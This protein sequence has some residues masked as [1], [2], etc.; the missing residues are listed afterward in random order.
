MKWLWP[1]NFLNPPAGHV[2]L[3]S[4]QTFFLFC[5]CCPGSRGS[6]LRHHQGLC[7]QTAAKAEPPFFTFV[8]SVFMRAVW[9]DCCRTSRRCSRSQPC[10]AVPCRATPRH[11]GRPWLID[12][13]APMNQWA[14]RLFNHGQ[15]LW[16]LITASH[17]AAP[18]LA[19]SALFKRLLGIFV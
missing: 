12:W 10:R 4:N 3:A 11:A 9:C 16:T 8:T 2:S 14:G 5:F 1:F 18:P 6:R 19:A 17:P 13:Y 15:S 7:A